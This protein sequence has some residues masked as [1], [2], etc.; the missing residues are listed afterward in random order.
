MVSLFFSYPEQTHGSPRNHWH[1]APSEAPQ[2]SASFRGPASPVNPN[3][4]LFYALF[5][6]LISSNQGVLL[7]LPI[8]APVLEFLNLDGIASIE[9]VVRSVYRVLWLRHMP[10]RYVLCPALVEPIVLLVQSMRLNRTGFYHNG[11][12]MSPLQSSS[13]SMVLHP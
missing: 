13:E 5:L 10:A 11:G 6:F 8:L 3:H 12:F 2:S 7:R 1:S 9:Y 4:P